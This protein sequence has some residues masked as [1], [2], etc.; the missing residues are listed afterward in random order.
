MTM[1]TLSPG[2]VPARRNVRGQGR[3]DGTVQEKFFPRSHVIT[4]VTV[5]LLRLSFTPGPGMPPGVPE[6]P[7]EPRDLKCEKQGHVA[8]DGHSRFSGRLLG[9]GRAMLQ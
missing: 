6:K 8:I 3:A 7:L 4:K 1:V 5:A 2:T 9:E